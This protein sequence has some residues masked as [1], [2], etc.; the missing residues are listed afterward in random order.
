MGTAFLKKYW[1]KYFNHSLPPSLPAKEPVLGLSMSYDIVTKAHG[2]ELKVETK[3][4]GVGT[5]SALFYQQIL[6][7]NH[8]N[9]SS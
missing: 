8:E 2:G 3:D 6:H 4:E 7:S 1:I 9:F 5:N